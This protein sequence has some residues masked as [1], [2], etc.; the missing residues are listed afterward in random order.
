MLG[1]VVEKNEYGQEVVRFVEGKDMNGNPIEPLAN[2]HGLQVTDFTAD[3][4]APQLLAYS[5]DMDKGHLH[6]TFDE[7]VNA[8]TMDVTQLTLSN[9]ATSAT[10]GPSTADSAS[11]LVTSSAGEIW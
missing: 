8:T 4:I 11:P 3:S 6:L 9:A 7:T 10:S 2:S 5:I 1:I